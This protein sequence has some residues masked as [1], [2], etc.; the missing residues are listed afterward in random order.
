[1]GFYK[2][3]YEEGKMIRYGPTIDSRKY[4][5]IFL[6]T[7]I[8]LDEKLTEEEWNKL[9]KKFEMVGNNEDIS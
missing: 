9:L 7:K 1:M 4:D 5:D 2:V 6:L 3:K 8:A